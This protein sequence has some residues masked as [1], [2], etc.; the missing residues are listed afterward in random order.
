MFQKFYLHHNLLI[1]FH[2]IHTS[3]V[4]GK[5]I[6]KTFYTTDYKKS[7]Y[8]GCST[9]GRQG[10]KSAQDFP[11][12]FDGIV[13]G[14]P[15]F[16]FANLSA[17]SGHFYLL[18]G[19][20][21][22]PTFLT[23]A[24]WTT[25]HQ[26]ILSQCDSLDGATDNIIEDPLYCNYDPTT[27][28]CNSTTNPNTTSTCL[29]PAQISTV[30]SVFSPLYGTNNTFIYPRMQPGSELNLAIDLLYNGSPFP[31]TTDWARYA[32]YND[33]TWDPTTLNPTD[34]D[35]FY[36]INPGN[37]QSFSGNLTAFS[38]RGSKILHWHGQADG[39]ISSE[40]SPVY[41]N[42]VLETMNAT[43]ATLDEFYRFFRVSGTGHCGNGD[44]AWQIGQ[45]SQGFTTT[46]PEANVLMAMVRWV[47]EGVAPETVE[48][49]KYVDDDPEQ[50][51]EIVRKHCR[52][53]LTN[54]FVGVVGEEGHPDA[55]ECVPRV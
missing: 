29:S 34:Y 51:V 1:L 12:D 9:G 46:D 40:I 47:E 25:V 19:P 22:S 6:T 31:Y 27:L 37:I 30:R 33:I 7:Y 53:P 54:R 15:A 16:A 36:T 10:W 52:Y 14:A 48:G 11:D 38:S 24:E 8:L 49:T 55:W 39:L 18:T 20:P 2:S 23:R 43:P 28:A 35:N 3:T 45:S 4:V 41:Y 26:D 32:V 50:G 42:H 44:G 13:A 5:Q 21:D 17:T